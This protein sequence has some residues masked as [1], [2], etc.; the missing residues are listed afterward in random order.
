MGTSIY[1]LSPAGRSVRV[2]N[3]PGEVAG[4][5]S[6]DSGGWAGRGA[7]LSFLFCAE[8]NGHNIFRFASF[9]Q[10]SSSF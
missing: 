2:G 8:L 4:A 5:E 7:V 3:A 10:P 1:F 9:S 6:H